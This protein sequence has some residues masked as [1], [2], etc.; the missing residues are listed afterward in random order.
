MT[1]TPAM[2]AILLA[3]HASPRHGYALME[4]V[5]VLTGGVITLGPATLY[6][7]LQRLR[8]DGLIEELGEGP[9][10]GTPA[11]RRAERRRSYRITAAGRSATT[12]EAHRLAVMVAAARRIGVVA[13]KNRSAS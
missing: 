5:N 2:F 12:E 7:S 10:T 4:D 13:D 8:V 3:L 11:D 6:R 9:P 1:L